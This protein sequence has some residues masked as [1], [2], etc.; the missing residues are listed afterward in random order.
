MKKMTK[1]PDKKQIA[2][3]MEH[4]MRKKLEVSEESREIF[5]KT[6]TRLFKKRLISRRLFDDYMRL[7]KANIR[8]I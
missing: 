2:K 8:K 1:V 3:F 7:T 5:T 4:A 6:V